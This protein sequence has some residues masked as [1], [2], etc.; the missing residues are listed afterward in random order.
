MLQRGQFAAPFR[1]G[2]PACETIPLLQPA[3]RIIL[4][5]FIPVCSRSG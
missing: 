5:R 1:A 2:Y 3:P 4:N